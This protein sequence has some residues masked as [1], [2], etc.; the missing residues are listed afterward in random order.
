MNKHTIVFCEGEH[1]IAF[2]TRILLV[3]G[4]QPY[5]EKVK[6]FAPPFNDLYK[7]N[8]ANK[9]IENYEFKFQRPK[10][11]VPYSVLTNE[12][13][14][15]IF[16][17]LDG[18]GAFFNGGA[19]RVQKMYLELNKENIR[20]IKGYDRLNY[21]FLYFLDS[22]EQGV[23]SRLSELGKALKIDDL[24]N[25]TLVVNDDYELGC[26]VFHDAEHPEYHGKLED[27]IVKLMEV[28]NNQ[29]LTSGIKFIDDNSLDEG[30]CKRFVCNNIAEAYSG[31]PQFKKKKSMIS[32][33][34]QLQFSGSSNAVIIAN[35]DYLRKEHLIDNFHCKNIFNLFN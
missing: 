34:G 23:E 7:K 4:F 25:H 35:S 17:N 30:R 13:M 16:H 3:Q 33:A 26:Y 31:N 27:I 6:N 28:D 11:T 32:I 12:N 10:Q 22:D 24:N 9:K 2:L 21:R 20:K 1:D 5:K 18:D 29:I 8:L 15:V 14:L 19:E